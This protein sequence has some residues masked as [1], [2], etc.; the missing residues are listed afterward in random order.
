MKYG[1]KK[2]SRN[3]KRIMPLIIAFCVLTT[4]VYTAYA[5]NV[6]AHFG[7][8]DYH[9]NSGQRFSVGFYLDMPEG[10]VGKYHVELLFDANRL[11]YESGADKV[12][13]N[14]LI[15]E[16]DSLSGGMM[17]YWL[18]FEAT[19]G[20]EAYIKVNEEGT[21]VHAMDSA[22]TQVY[23]VSA[24]SPIYIAG[25]DTALEKE[26]EEKEKAEKEEQ[27]RLEKERKEQEEKAAKEKAEKEEAERLAKEQAEKEEQERKAREE[28]EAKERAEEEARRQQEEQQAEE[29]R[30]AKLEKY[31]IIGISALVVI[32][33]ILLVVSIK[34]KKAK[35]SL[36]EDNEEANIE[37]FYSFINE[38]SFDNKIVFDDE[39]SNDDG[40]SSDNKIIFD[41]EKSS[42]NENTSEDSDKA[43]NKSNDDLEKSSSDTDEKEGYEQSSEEASEESGGIEL[44][45]FDDY[46]K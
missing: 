32:V 35:R 26:Q 34:K 18:I 4:V 13:G 12:E 17:K 44:I 7:S 30:I 45:N 8:T 15:F 27:E 42:D 43:N 23:S 11:K 28:Q 9:V 6:G 38:K 10:G 41:D 36:S 16:G 5:F 29:E 21:E 1:Y 20:G 3:M 19:S 31:A 25:T 46:T 2:L 22:D 33:V 24:S 40:K 37:D 14:K 39:K